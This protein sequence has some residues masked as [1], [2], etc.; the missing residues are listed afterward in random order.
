MTVCL[1]F[2]S[3]GTVLKCTVRKRMVRGHMHQ[4]AGKSWC[5]NVAIPIVTPAVDTKD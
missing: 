4:G 2:T 3:Y 1:G 5:G